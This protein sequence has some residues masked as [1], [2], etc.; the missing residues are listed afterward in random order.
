MKLLVLGRGTFLE[1]GSP[2]PKPTPSSPK[3]FDF[4]ESLMVIVSGLK[5]VAHQRKR[6]S[7]RIRM[8]FF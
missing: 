5:I 7:I 6:K 8:L 3:T 2:S 4:I 1:K